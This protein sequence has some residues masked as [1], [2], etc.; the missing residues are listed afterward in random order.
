MLPRAIRPFLPIRFRVM[1][2][3]IGWDDCLIHSGRRGKEPMRLFPKIPVASACALVASVLMC[4][5]QSATF[6]SQAIADAFVTTGPDGS[7]SSSN[8]G[9]AGALAVSASGL[10]Q[11]EFQSV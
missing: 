6:T 7:L 11:G 4:P 3:F 10:P 1:I 2:H 5:G 9:A 8:F